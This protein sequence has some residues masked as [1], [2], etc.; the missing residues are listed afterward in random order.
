MSGSCYGVFLANNSTRC[1]SLLELEVLFG[2]IR[3]LVGGNDFSIIWG[4]HLDSYLYVNL[5]KL[6]PT[7][8]VFHVG[9]QLQPAFLYGTQPHV[10]GPST[11]S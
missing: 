1:N 4:L 8:V 9:F 11:L 10:P 5:K 6:L 2:G 7:V 3:C